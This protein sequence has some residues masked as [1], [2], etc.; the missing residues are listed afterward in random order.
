AALFI[1]AGPLGWIP[2]IMLP[3][4]IGI[5]IALQRP[6]DRAMRRLQ[7]ESSARHGILI[8]SLSGMETVR[9][10]GG[11][12]RVQTGWERSVAATARSSED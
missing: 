7:A 2:L 5:G 10:I 11:E 12:A 9:S 8:E 6:L 3:I 1:V 4:M